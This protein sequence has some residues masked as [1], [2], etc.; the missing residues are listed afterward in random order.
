[1]RREPI[2]TRKATLASLLRGCGVGLRLVEHLEHGG[3][4]RLPPRLQARL[5]GHCVKAGRLEISSRPW[6]VFGLD[7]GEESGSA[8][9]RREA[10][11]DWGKRR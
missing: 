1:M 11:E 8:G 2:E 7:Q 5:R 3:E 10:E 4:R 9:V 6:Q